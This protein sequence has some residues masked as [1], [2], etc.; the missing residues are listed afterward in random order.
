MRTSWVIRHPSS[1]CHTALPAGE[2]VVGISETLQNEA[3]GIKHKSTA[4]TPTHSR[5]HR[6]KARDT[7]S[8][9]HSGQETPVKKRTRM[10]MNISEE[11]ENDTFS[12]YNPTVV[13]YRYFGV[14]WGS[15][16]TV[17][18]TVGNLLTVLAFASD[19]RLRTHFNVL[20][21]NLA[22]ADLLYCSVLQPVSVD[23]YL[24]LRWR[25]GA[26]WCRVFGLLLFLSNSVSILTLCLIAVGR[27]ILIAK[28]ALFQRLFSGVGL[29]LL[30][31][32]TWALGFISFG[33][34]WPFYVFTPQVCTCSFHRSRGRPYTTVLLFMYFFLGLGCV[35]LFYFLIYRRV[36]VAAGALQ[37][38]RLSRRSSRKKPAGGNETTEGDSGIISGTV[39]HSSE[40]SDPS[41]G[42]IT[43][44]KDQHPKKPQVNYNSVATSNPSPNDPSKREN[45]QPAPAGSANDDGEFA[46]VT[47]MCFTVF[48]CFTC[49]F[50]PFILLNIFDRGNRAPQ[51][52][53]MF[54]ANLTWLNS[55]IN[56]VLYA[57]MNRQFSQAYRALLTRAAW[58]VTVL[59]R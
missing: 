29:V 57:A 7:Q 2:I 25:G 34:L 11:Q 3:T 26:R 33:P 1:I 14:L 41:V 44:A 30:L 32:S 16:V 50:V 51:A 39:T 35:G 53:H 21:V 58:P 54:C 13:E 52:V 27:Y 10:I 49:C 38:Y 19:R 12:C 31:S 15:L 5:T 46:R 42:S 59:C 6:P 9:R 22:I 43:K 48:I 4:P 56:P 28:R 55:C 8:N 24:H 20:I 40:V 36:R 47:R 17:V 18:G 45:P 23:S 37:K